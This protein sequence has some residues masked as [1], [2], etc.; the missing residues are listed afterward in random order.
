MEGIGTADALLAQIS[1]KG[2]FEKKDSAKE[3]RVKVEIARLKI[4][5]I[6]ELFVPIQPVSLIVNYSEKIEI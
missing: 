1:P 4:D 6:E 2:D 5:R 3:A